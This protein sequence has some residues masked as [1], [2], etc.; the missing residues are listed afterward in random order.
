MY[1]ALSHELVG[2]RQPILALEPLDDLDDVFSG[3][4]LDLG[5]LLA[6]Y[7]KYLQRLKD[8]GLNPWQDQSRRKTDHQLTE[9]VGHFHLYTWLKG[10]IGRRCVISPE[11]PTGN[12]KV[13]L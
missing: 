4:A 2:D 3:P 10:A 13:D 6:R 7:K 11:F 1:D 12:G 9:A 8:K 5:A